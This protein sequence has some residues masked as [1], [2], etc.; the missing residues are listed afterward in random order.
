M[1][2]NKWVVLAKKETTYGTDASPT[3]ADI[4]YTNNP[5]VEVVSKELERTHPMSNYGKNA[6]IN[7]GETVKISFQMELQCDWDASAD[8]APS[9]GKVLEACNFTETINT[10]TDITYANNSSQNGDS[11]TIW[12]YKDGI[13]YKVPGCRGELKGSHKSGEKVNFDFEF[14]GIYNPTTYKSDATFPTFTLTLNDVCIFQNGEIAIGSY[15]SPIVDNFNWAMNNEIVKRPDANSNKGIYSIYVKNSAPTVSV[16]PEIVALATYN[17]QSLWEANTLVDLSCAFKH[18]S[19]TGFEC[20]LTISNMQY[21]DV[22][23]GERDNIMTYDINLE[24]G[25]D[26]SVTLVFEGEAA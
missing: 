17:A 20:N 5:A 22:K 11:L 26:T 10:G 21:K 2:A 6:R 13:L 3:T 9:V 14:E 4:I 7:I 24:T 19:T 18:P 1:N 25:G 16:D 8:T 23:D 12:V 15:A